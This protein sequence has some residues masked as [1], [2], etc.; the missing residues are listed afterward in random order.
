MFRKTMIAST[1]LIGMAGA[2]RAQEIPGAQA[3]LLVPAEAGNVVGGGA[4]RLIGGGTESVV[5]REG[6]SLVQPGRAARLDTTGGGE[7]ELYYIEPVAP[8]ARGRDALLLGGGDNAVVV[9][10]DGRQARQG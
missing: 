5:Q 10:F 8:G 4:A 3:T 1:L 9:Y 7:V 2:A 6:T